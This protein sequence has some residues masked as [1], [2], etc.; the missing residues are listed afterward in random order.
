VAEVEEDP[1]RRAFQ[2]ELARM[3]AEVEKVGA[4]VWLV[5]PLPTEAG[6]AIRC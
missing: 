5:C 2:E 3:A 6:R 4:C 1:E